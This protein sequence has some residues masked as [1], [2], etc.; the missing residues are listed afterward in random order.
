MADIKAHPVD[1]PELD[2][3]IERAADGLADSITHAL[4]DRPSTMLVCVIVWA[5]SAPVHFFLNAT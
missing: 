5:L 3:A 4:H 2:G 1:I